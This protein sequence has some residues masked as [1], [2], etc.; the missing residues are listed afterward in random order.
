MCAYNHRKVH[1]KVSNDFLKAWMSLLSGK[2]VDRLIFIYY[3]SG[4]K[5]RQTPPKWTLKT[6]L[7]LGPSRERDWP[8]VRNVLTVLTLFLL[9]FYQSSECQVFFIL[10]DTI[11][12]ILH[13]VC[14]VLMVLNGS[15][16]RT[17]TKRQKSQSEYQKVLEHSG[18]SIRFQPLEN[19]VNMV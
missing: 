19:I 3:L 14:L 8:K 5:A 17:W 2:K 1:L 10:Q 4:H 15:W 18:C 16:R 9:E 6:V 12:N 7:C 13:E 11:L